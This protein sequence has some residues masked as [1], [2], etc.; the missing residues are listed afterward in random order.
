MR[1][2]TYGFTMLLISLNSLLGEKKVQLIK[3]WHQHRVCDGSIGDKFWNSENGLF[4]TTW[5]QLIKSNWPHKITAPLFQHRSKYWMSIKS[6]VSFTQN[7]DLTEQSK[8]RSTFKSHTDFKQSRH[9][10]LTAIYLLIV[11]MPPIQKFIHAQIVNFP[12]N[13]YSK[14]HA[15]HVMFK[16]SQCVNSP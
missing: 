14:I 8:N 3:S 16:D 2:L 5:F 12:Q 6:L 9:Y 15:N 1:V 4:D 13:E 7:Y 11:W 10:L